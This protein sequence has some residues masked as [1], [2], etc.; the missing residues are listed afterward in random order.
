[1]DLESIPIINDQKDNT[2]TNQVMNRSR[3]LSKPA[4]IYLTASRASSKFTGPVCLHRFQVR[5]TSINNH[6]SHQSTVGGASG[7]I[8][9]NRTESH[10]I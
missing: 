2:I 9:N 8:F 3:D 6:I 7:N 10:I 1:M 4:S 5:V